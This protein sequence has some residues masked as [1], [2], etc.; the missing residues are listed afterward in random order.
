[1]F[2]CFNVSQLNA[3][4]HVGCQASSLISARALAVICVAYAFSSFHG[5]ALILSIW[6]WQKGVSEHAALYARKQY[7]HREHC[8]H[9]SPFTKEHMV[10]SWS[11]AKHGC[12]SYRLVGVR[13]EVLIKQGIVITILMRMVR[14][15]LTAETL[16][17]PDL[18]R[19]LRGQACLLC[20]PVCILTGVCILDGPA[21]HLVYIGKEGPVCAR[22]PL[23]STMWNL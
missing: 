2:S 22:A 14:V 12:S 7:G 3:S 19:K 23:G 8:E 4:A 15:G 17:G 13:V 21:S 16:F 6:S 10:W 1:M 9:R 5:P 20:S 18:E 11:M